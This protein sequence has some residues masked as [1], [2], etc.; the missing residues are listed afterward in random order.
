VSFL[1]DTNVVS[2][3]RK[4]RPHAG[5]AAWYETVDGSDLYLSVLV[6]GE[7]QQG[8]TRL[9]RRDRRQATTY[10]TWLERLQAGFAD[11]ILPVSREVALEWG[12]L[13]AVDP[14]PVVDGLMAATARVH[15]LTFVTR[16][17]VDVA[18]TG[19]A[20]LNPFDD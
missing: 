8:V 15:G 4:T 6:L 14:P 18:R 20:L 13:S 12:R 3:V 1:L 5:V 9:R 19:A 10:E 7:I 16:N 11:R 2:E 17:V